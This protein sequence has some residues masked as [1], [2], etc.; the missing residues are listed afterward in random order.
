LEFETA[1]LIQYWASAHMDMK[2]LDFKSS[3]TGPRKIN[4]MQLSGPFQILVGGLVFSF[5]ILVCEMCWKK[6]KF[7]RKPRW[8]FLLI[9]KV[10][11]R[12]QENIEDVK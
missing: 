2:Y 6:F 4:F 1:G 10:I 12:P 7:R 9:L 5:M 3:K 8:N 11:H